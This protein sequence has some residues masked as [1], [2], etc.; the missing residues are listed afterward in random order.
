MTL[1]FS[2]GKAVN[3]VV[4]IMTCVTLNKFNIHISQITKTISTKMDIIT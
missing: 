4:K 2:R 1:R 3:S